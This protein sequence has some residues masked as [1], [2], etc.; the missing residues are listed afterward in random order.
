MS[1]KGG[2]KGS[3][4]RKGKHWSHNVREIILCKADGSFNLKIDGGAENGEFVYVG[5]IKEKKVKYK[6]GK[7][8]VNDIVLEVNANAVAGFTR[9]DFL[10]LINKDGKDAV[11]LRTV[12]PGGGIMRDLREYL[13]MR[14]KDSPDIGLQQTIRDNLYRRTVPCTTR[15]PRDGEVPGVD[16]VFLSLEE[17]KTMER[18]GVFIETGNYDGNSYGTPKPPKVPTDTL[19]N[20]P[21]PASRPPRPKSINMM[22][23]TFE[24]H[25]GLNE[26]NANYLGPLPLPSKWEV[27]YTE[28]NEK[29]F[30]N[31]S[32][33]KTQYDKPK[34]Q[35]H[36]S[37]YDAEPFLDQSL[38]PS[39]NHVANYQKYTIEE[40][41]FEGEL[42]RSTLFKGS[43]GF[44]F[45]IIGGD[46]PGELLQIK[47][48]VADGAA[49]PGGTG[50]FP[51]TSTSG[52]MPRTAPE[53]HYVKV[54]KGPMGFGFTI[55]DSPYGQKV[56][57]ILDAPRCAELQESDILLEINNRQIRNLSHREAVEMLKYCPKGKEAMLVI[58]RGGIP[59]SSRNSPMS[60]RR[61]EELRSSG[62]KVRPKSTPPLGVNQT[63]RRPSD[64]KTG[65]WNNLAT[66]GE[67]TRNQETGYRDQP[68]PSL[69]RGNDDGG[70]P[71]DQVNGPYDDVTNITIRRGD[72]GFGFRV[73]G[74]I[75]EKTQASIGTVVPGSPAE[76]DG[77][78]QRD[79][80]IVHVDSKNVI[81]SSHHHVISLIHAAAAKGWVTLGI[82][83]GAPRSGRSTPARRPSDSSQGRLGSR[84]AGDL[85]QYGPRDDEERGFQPPGRDRR[86]SESDKNDPDVPMKH[87]D[88]TLTRA[89]HE[90]FGFV[91]T[92]SHESGSTIGRI[93]PGSPSDRCR[94]LF[95]G[96]KLVAVNGS[97]IAGM[98]HSDIVN[99]IKQ[100]GTSVDLTIAQ[101]PLGKSTPNMNRARTDGYVSDGDFYQRKQRE[102]QRRREDDEAF[103]RE[104]QRRERE[105]KRIQEERRIEEERRETEKR[106]AERRETE[107]RETERREAERKESERREAE[108]RREEDIRREEDRKR[109]DERRRLEDQRRDD[110]KRWAQ[111]REEDRRWEAERRRTLEKKTFE[112]ER[113]KTGRL[114]DNVR[115]ARD[116]RRT[117]EDRKQEEYKR[118][119]EIRKREQESKLQEELRRKTEDSRRQEEV[120]R[121]VEEAARQQEDRARE[122]ERRRREEEQIRRVT[123]DTQ[124]H[125][126]PPK[127]AP[128]PI[129]PKPSKAKVAQAREERL[130]Y[131]T[132]PA[133]Q[134]PPPQAD[135]SR[136]LSGGDSRPKQPSQSVY[137][138]GKS[139][140]DLGRAVRTNNE[141][142]TLEVELY[143][144]SQGYG[145][146]I[147]GGRELGMPIFVLKIAEGGIADVDGRVKVGDEILAIN[148][149]ST[150]D[151]LHTDAIDMIRAGNR[152]KLTLIRNFGPPVFVCRYT[153]PNGGPRSLSR[154][155]YGRDSSASHN[156]RPVSYY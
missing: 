35:I 6:K 24:P 85:T 101:K 17:F 111:E 71:Q 82:Q 49:G 118:Q 36:N 21:K 27:G 15:L 7:L 142:D 40:R 62:R 130:G 107:R 86:R 8:H 70:R 77:N 100:S 139:E 32:N 112:E 126:P 12:K 156:P 52:S 153:L 120:R 150:K 3:L 123:Q 124:S 140:S 87:R 143:K 116:L 69:R 31:H 154:V 37:D 104:R 39:Y 83:R 43:R 94:Q 67:S 89:D 28:E 45:T 122:E 109:V 136:R 105:E 125:P 146:S 1:N 148:N 14:H 60:E 88:I 34:F 16:Y 66:P 141:N 114:D 108:K 22:E 42:I 78:L 58:Q 5:G 138:R 18:R 97:N 11:V 50:T 92:S 55:A 155:E 61:T 2:K 134:A 149:R 33:M 98:H 26:K 128:P 113:R 65:S 9:P 144:K 152:V 29:Y 57:Q 131:S 72:M 95:V 54:V 137:L 30:I 73:V 133:R 68:Y 20:V 115:G 75:E 13:A 119:D 135:R 38:P 145:F 74:G 53:V 103:E 121:R 63:Q 46:E 44:G 127:K 79:D 59:T 81:G 99:I 48:I 41:Q 56:K 19:R 106:E 110:E 96:D 117:E 102:D 64:Q 90:G 25:P 10:T 51:R 93:V 132:L 129:L 147:R 47:N 91:V 80:I 4:P 76:I 23:P 84:S 151:L